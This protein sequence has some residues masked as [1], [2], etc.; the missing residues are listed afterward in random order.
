MFKWAPVA[1]SKHRTVSRMT[2]KSSG[3]VTKTV[4]YQHR[5]S[6][7]FDVHSVAVTRPKGFC[8]AVVRGL[9]W[10]LRKV[11]C[12]TGILASCHSGWRLAAKCD[13]WLKRISGPC[14]TLFVFVPRTIRS[15]RNSIGLWPSMYVI[16]YQ[17]LLGSPRR[18][19]TWV[20]FSFPPSQLRPLQ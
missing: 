3:F 17:R 1:F 4:T 15:V 10:T 6:L 12:S 18:L 20:S 16:S 13:H 19:R 14:N 7:L 5:Q 8:P 11:P 9:G 2:R